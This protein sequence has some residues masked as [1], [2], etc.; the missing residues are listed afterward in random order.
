MDYNYDR[1]ENLLIQSIKKHL[2]LDKY[3]DGITAMKALNAFYNHYN[4]VSLKQLYYPELNEE[5]Y[6]PDGNVFASVGDIF[7]YQGRTE[8]PKCIN[9]ILRFEHHF[10][11]Y[12][13][14]EVVELRLYM[15][16]KPEDITESHRVSSHFDD[17]K[18]MDIKKNEWFKK[19]KNDKPLDYSIDINFN[20]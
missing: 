1:V 17:E 6:C 18:I 10:Y 15:F 2:N 11:G 5:I 9:R 16:Y 4:Q 12:F 20:A 13:E 3:K 14:Y 8:N 7:S 19:I